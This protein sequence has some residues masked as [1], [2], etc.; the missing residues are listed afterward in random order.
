MEIKYQ[1][2]DKAYKYETNK[3]IALS[4]LMTSI[5][6]IK[7]FFTQGFA[8]GQFRIRIATSLYGLGYIFPFLIVPIW[9]LYLIQVPYKVFAMSICIG[10]VIPGIV[11]VILVKRLKMHFSNH[12]H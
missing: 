12:L 2:D 8:F 7:M 5:Y 11:G 9:L 3:K 4:A 10:Q 1:I 6:I